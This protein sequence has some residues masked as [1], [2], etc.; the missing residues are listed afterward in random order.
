MAQQHSIDEITGAQKAA[1]LVVGLGTDV[2]S[3]V[4]KELAEPE[5]EKLTIQVANLKDIPPSLEEQVLKEVS[6]LIMAQKYIN[7]GGAEYARD[8][9]ESA[10]GKSRAME[11]LKRLEGS[12]KATGFAMVKDIDPKQLINFIQNEHPQTISL[13]LTQLSHQQA[14]QILSDLPPELQAEVSLRIATMEKISPTI[15]NELEGV[16]EGQFEEAGSRDLSLSG[17]TKMV[18]EIL[19]L[20]DSSTEKAIMESIE[21]EN[22]ELAAEIKNLMFI[23]E[24]ILLLDDRSI[25]RVLKEVETKELAIA[26]KAA[27]EEIKTKIF[28]NV[29]ERVAE[30]IR[31]EIEFMG[32]M[33]LSDVEAAQQKIVETV[34]RLQDEGQIIIAGRGGKEELVV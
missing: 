19:N 6:E 12:L 33:R 3:K 8:I 20:M 29:S 16:L 2:S 15:I 17:G 21:N 1:I 10:F 31:E 23:F 7:Q 28:S 14:S 22:P 4:L 32:P 27:S 26:L 25:Q 11:I 24:D 34:R 9:L 30:M 13:I 18:A 5:I